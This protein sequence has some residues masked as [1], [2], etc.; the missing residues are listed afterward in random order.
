MHRDLKPDN[1]LMNSKCEVSIADFG[2]SRVLKGT[3]DNN[4]LHSVKQHLRST[5][6]DYSKPNMTQ[7]QQAFR[8]RMSRELEKNKDKNKKRDKSEHMSSR[9][10]RAPE[11]I[12]MEK[13]YD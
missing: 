3:D 6:L 10:Y 2:L 12:F 1:I 13:D 7:D 4:S 8:T 5:M 11:V 9:W